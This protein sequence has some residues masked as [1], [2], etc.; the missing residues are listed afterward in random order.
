MNQ[1]T[2]RSIPKHLDQALRAHSAKN[3]ESL[4]KT[5]LR[6]LQKALGLT[7]AHSGKKRDLTSLS[8]TWNRQEER[9]FQK[10]IAIFDTIDEELWK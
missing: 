5:V 3:K 4:N 7:H 10:N 9:Q 8:G 2:L 6:L 1:M